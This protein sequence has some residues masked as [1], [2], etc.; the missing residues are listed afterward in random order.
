[1]RPVPFEPVPWRP[2]A[3]EPNGRVE[4]E[5]NDLRQHLDEHEVMEGRNGYTAIKAWLH[6]ARRRRKLPVAMRVDL[7]EATCPY[8]ECK[9]VFNNIRGLEQHL[10]AVMRH[11]VY[12]CCGRPFYTQHGRERHVRAV[13]GHYVV[14][15][16]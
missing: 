3:P 15:A 4:V 14:A 13:H 10:T 6:N 12:L 11:P 8:D 5:R 2:A 9:A 7:S 1:M 16:L